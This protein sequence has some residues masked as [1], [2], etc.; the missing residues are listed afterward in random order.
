M[1]YT[2]PPLPYSYDALEPHIDARTM[3]IHYTK[4]HQT[5]V[6][7][8]NAVLEK[9]PALAEEK[10]EDLMKKWNELTIPEADKM[11][12]RN[13][14]GGHLNHSF[15]WNLMDP[16]KEIDLKLSKEIQASFSSVDEFKK[17]FSD[18]AAA[19]FG[20]GWC[21]LV[22]DASG[23]LMIYSLPNQDSPLMSGHTPVISLDV[24]EHAYYLKYQNKRAD[25]IEAWWKVVKII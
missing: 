12:I 9:H 2:L 19:L 7:K 14:G 16:K 1:K 3:E 11:A 13:H 25:Y 20:S 22:R 6:D 5:Y 21:H 10:L 18:K 23:K 4:H 24:W 15:F 8:L 17:L